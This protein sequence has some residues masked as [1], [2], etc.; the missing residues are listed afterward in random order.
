ML[1]C[2]PILL[3]FLHSVI[4]PQGLLQHQTDSFGKL[5]R[6]MGVVQRGKEGVR[7]ELELA[8]AIQEHGEAF[9][10]AYPDT[11]VKPKN[12][13]IHHVPLQLARD[14]LIIDAFVGERKHQSI[15]AL[16][17]DVQNTTRFEQSVIKRAVAQQMAVLMDPMCFRYGLLRAKPYP[18]LAASQGAHCAFVS[19]RMKWCG[20]TISAGDL[21]VLDGVVC[22]VEACVS[23]DEKLAVVSKRYAFM[24][25]AFWNEKGGPG[26]L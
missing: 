6:V 18:E 25:K 4:A 3:Y 17:S 21:L 12:H 16:A 5:G 22:S 1:L 23:V 2:F 15:K 7:L 24:G 19:T 13:Y 26:D 20:T 10:L 9:A 14:G 8:R 11:E